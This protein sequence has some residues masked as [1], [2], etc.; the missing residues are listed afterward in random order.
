M[1][2][3]LGWLWRGQFREQPGRTLTALLAIALGV[4]LASAIALVNRSGLDEFGRAIA[5]INGDAQWRVVP[6]GAAFDEE[7]I[8]A[9]A[10][11]PRVEEASPT[12]EIE[13]GRAEP[14]GMS[15]S[16]T[17]GRAAPAPPTRRAPALRLLG[18]DAMR[19]A[20]VTPGLLP[21][22]RTDEA[23]RRDA[24]FAADALF[25]S[26]AAL[27]A[28]SLTPGDRLAVRTGL[29]TVPLRIEGDLPGAS[30]GQL[31][32][33]IDI[34]A[35]Q[36]RFGWLG[37][38]N[39]IDLRLR[40]G[41]D[42]HAFAED[43]NRRLAPAARIVSPASA[44]QRMSNLSRAY[45]VNLNVLAL[46]ALLTGGFLVHATL[47]LVVTRQRRTLALLAVLGMRPRWI[48]THM[49]AQGLVLGTVGSALGVV[50]G[51]GLARLMLTAL[52]SDLGGGY[53]DANP[54]VLSLDAGMLSLYAALGVVT[55]LLGSAL[56]AL[57]APA[58][59]AAR[60]LR[61]D[62]KPHTTPVALAW[63]A[64]AL[65]WIA[66]LLLL[67]VPPIDGLALAAYAAIACWLFA[68]VA[69]IRPM[70]LGWRGCARYLDARA[71]MR[72]SWW[73]A[74]RRLSV[75][76]EDSA[77]AALGGVVASV[78]LA[79][80]MAIMVGSFRQSVDQWLL[81]VLPA[82]LYLRAGSD[83][84]AGALSIDLQHAMT[85]AP[86]IERT[87]FLRAQGL[88]LEPALPKVM[89]IARDVDARQPQARVPMTGVVLPRMPGTVSIYASE[90]MADL[91]GLRP[92]TVTSLP[93]GDGRSRF[94][95]RALWRD[96]ARQ[97]GTILIDRG[98]Y[99]TLTGDD[100]V[101]DAALWLREGADPTK[102]IDTLR[103]EL[104]EIAGLEIRSAA[105][106]RALSL[107]VFDRSFA[108]TYALEAIAMLVGLFGVTATY[109]G[110]ALARAREF[111]MMRHLGITRRQ[112]ARQLALESMMLI[113]TGA[114]WGLMVAGALAWVLIERVNPQ[115][116]HW[117]MD[118]SVPWGLLGGSALLL[119]SL[120]TFAAVIAARHA[121]GAYPV[122]A[123]REDW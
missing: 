119:I 31:L 105:E 6:T 13:V 71:W 45:R 102:V 69:W 81:A 51:V 25:L 24:A 78:A 59:A 11:D 8:V 47:A 101:N 23:G 54:P 121:M 93:I 89:L 96:Y 61:G 39:G 75:A 35:L 26:P 16:D 50:T 108:I 9:L 32:G 53:F 83:G 76:A 48:A 110:E 117:T 17:A 107:R 57:R 34:A 72:P 1:I 103:I 111:G 49:L 37:R 91:Y 28:W 40:A 77:A 44:H 113:S 7:V 100:S 94:H 80:A 15:E 95:V 79:G 42:A 65:W 115:S 118:V 62:D 14:A 41:I 99:R 5:V 20:R 97:H 22:P 116:F 68:G 84:G 73:L 82:D 21:R 98:D 33:V 4:A 64:G 10:S 63:M 92:G 43:W 55:A 58:F 52:G 3:L 87:E 12:I 114:A 104:P 70:L 38:L 27:R 74:L 30:E 109:T 120:G 46:V 66:G 90:A 60:G 85:R 88:T 86:E 36:W 2:T 18:I 29:S 56:P 67:H 122:R 123:V 112:V 19:A 106:V